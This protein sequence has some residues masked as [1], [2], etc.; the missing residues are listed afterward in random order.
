MENKEQNKI[1]VD[2][3]DAERFGRIPEGEFVV[4][5]E[6]HAY[7]EHADALE[8]LYREMTRT[9]QTEPGIIYYCLARN[10]KD[11]TIFHFFERYA[12]K[13]DFIRHTEGEGTQKILSSG[14]VRDTIARF[15]EPLK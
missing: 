11:R 10:T 2:A 5:G 3:F 8:A 12:S 14:W 4:Y 15:E 9:A 6:V 7:P 13:A 1:T